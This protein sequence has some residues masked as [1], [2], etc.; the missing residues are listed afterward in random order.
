MRITQTRIAAML[1]PVVVRNVTPSMTIRLLSARA[2]RASET[3]T[4][5]ARLRKKTIVIRLRNG[6][7]LSEAIPHHSAGNQK[8]KL[9]TTDAIAPTSA[10]SEAQTYELQSLMRIPYAVYCLKK[11]Q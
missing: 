10:R 7:A 1:N 8:T 4:A 5:S 11:K 9:S 2:G 6:T 3:I